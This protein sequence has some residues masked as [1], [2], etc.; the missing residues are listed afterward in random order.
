MVRA[1][2]PRTQPPRFIRQYLRLAV[3]AG[4]G[5][6]SLRGL[7]QRRCGGLR[8]RDVGPIAPATHRADVGGA[9]TT[10]VIPGLTVRTRADVG[11]ITDAL[12]AQPACCPPRCRDAP[13]PGRRA[14][15]HDPQQNKKVQ[16]RHRAD[17]CDNGLHAQADAKA[18]RDYS[19]HR[20]CDEQ[21]HPQAEDAAAEHQGLRGGYDVRAWWR[22]C[23]RVRGLRRGVGPPERI[24]FARARTLIR[25]VRACTHR[26]CTPRSRASTHSGAASDIP[27]RAPMR[28]SA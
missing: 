19:S 23:V 12:A 10:G 25:R 4:A 22:R 15:Q 5:A 7:Q 8:A 24:F 1:S 20:Q 28:R 26:S 14:H 6:A 11:P 18:P 13:Q 17:D 27:G 2:A 9:P 16:T 21:Y 3:R